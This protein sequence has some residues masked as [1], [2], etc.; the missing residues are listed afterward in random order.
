MWYCNRLCDSVN[1]LRSFFNVLAVDFSNTSAFKIVTAKCKHFGSTDISLLTLQNSISAP[2]KKSC[3]YKMFAFL[4]PVINMMTFCLNVCGYYYL[5]FQYP[6]C[7]H[8]AMTTATQTNWLVYQCLHCH[9][10]SAKWELR[11]WILQPGD[12]MYKHQ[13]WCRIT[14]KTEV[15]TAPTTACANRFLLFMVDWKVSLQPVRPHNAHNIVGSI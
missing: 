7:L 12:I 1:N 2:I 11:V 4:I 15:L 5:G 3:L 8:W 9:V 13:M 14:Q 10:D 6:W